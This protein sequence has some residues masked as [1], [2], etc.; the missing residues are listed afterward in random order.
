LEFGKNKRIPI[1]EKEKAGGWDRV[2]HLDGKRRG[3]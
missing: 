3:S 2:R 1:K